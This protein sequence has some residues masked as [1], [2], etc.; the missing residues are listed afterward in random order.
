MP[1]A[2]RVL[3]VRRQPRTCLQHARLLCHHVHLLHL[4]LLHL[5]LCVG[6]QLGV[7]R[8]L[9]SHHLHLLH[10]H[11]GLSLKLPLSLELLLLLL[12]LA[13]GLLLGKIIL[14]RGAM[15]CAAV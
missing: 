12:L 9:L 14:I 11:L 3:R 13:V 6:R 15:L 10:L 7:L 2:S 1:A 8:L 5:L 4:H